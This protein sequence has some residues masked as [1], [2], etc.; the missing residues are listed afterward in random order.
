MPLKSIGKHNPAEFRFEHDDVFGRIAQR[1]DLLCDLF[2]FGIH[3]LW[4][5]AVARRIASENWNFLLDGA[6]GTGDIIHR[7]HSQDIGDKTIIAADVSKKMLA[8]AE[9]RL[10]SLAENVRLQL[11]D[12]QA[13]PSIESDSVDAYSIS[14]ALKICDRS[15]VLQEA[16]RVLRP[17][18]LLT[19]A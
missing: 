10:H 1:Y 19:D 11:L 6:T 12:A 2:S 5:R 4:K 14:L 7:L 17:E 3:R 13:M 9:R 16:L 18:A 8:F 15:L